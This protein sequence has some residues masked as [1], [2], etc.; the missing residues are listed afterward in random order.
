MKEFITDWNIMPFQI[1]FVAIC[2]G[3]Y[4]FSLYVYYIFFLLSRSNKL[5]SKVK[6]IITGT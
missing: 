6:D 1:M 2:V 5:L 3:F 4:I